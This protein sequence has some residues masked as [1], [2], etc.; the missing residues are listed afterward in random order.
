MDEAVC[1]L[2]SRVWRAWV[3]LSSIA[4]REGRRRIARLF[5]GHCGGCCGRQQDTNF[6]LDSPG[7]QHYAEE[8]ELLMRRREERRR[9]RAAF[10]VS[11][12]VSA[13]SALTKN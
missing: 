12:R 9:G 6:L 2:Q 3:R 5:C 11:E 7:S 13:A 8:Q 4:R 1:R 10:D